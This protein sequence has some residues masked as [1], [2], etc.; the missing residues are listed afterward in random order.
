MTF[1]F[2]Y[3]LIKAVLFQSIFGLENRFSTQLSKK[4]IEI[5]TIKNLYLLK[6]KCLLAI[7]KF[8]VAE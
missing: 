2:W 1:C 3:P 6:Y 7:G 8:N 4:H 5:C